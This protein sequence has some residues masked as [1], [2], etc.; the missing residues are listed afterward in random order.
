ML[1]DTVQLALSF[2][3]SNLPYVLSRIPANSYRQSSSSVHIRTNLLYLH[4]S[5]LATLNPSNVLDNCGCVL[6]IVMLSRL[7][8]VV[9]FLN[10]S[11]ILSAENI[12]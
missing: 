9:L 6:R 2:Q 7:F 8:Y 1:D 5:H 11:L 12:L 4:M 3:Q 10:I